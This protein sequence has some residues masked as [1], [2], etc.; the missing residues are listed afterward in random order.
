MAKTKRVRTHYDNLQVSE[1]ASSTVIRAAYR[2]LSQRW[3]PDKNLDN[4]ERAKRATQIIN[5]AYR[6]LSDPDERRKHDAW[7]VRQRSPEGSEEEGSDYGESAASRET[8]ENSCSFSEARDGPLFTAAASGT[9]DDVLRAMR[10]GGRVD[11]F[12]TH[13]A[14]A[15]MWA[16]LKNSDRK[17]VNELVQCGALVNE[18]D[19]NG[20][21]ALHLAAQHNVPSVVYELLRHGANPSARD[22]CNQTAYDIAIENPAINSADGCYALREMEALVAGRRRKTG[23]KVEEDGLKQLVL[24]GVGAVF[25]FAVWSYM[26]W[27]WFIK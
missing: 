18:G 7:I 9:S 27:I 8:G 10:E 5:E 25:G 24:D 23:E 12:D 19:R 4:H 6:V 22:E 14:T 1:G 2:A 16:A 20:R 17:V 26:I 3:H 21:T 13:G 11:V 15:L